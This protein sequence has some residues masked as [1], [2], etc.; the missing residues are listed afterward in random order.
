MRTLG[1]QWTLHHQIPLTSAP[2]PR[3]HCS[4]C[5]GVFVWSGVFEAWC[6]W[7]REA[8]PFGG[9]PLVASPDATLAPSL[10]N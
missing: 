5:S 8:D 1:I 9:H 10:P 6:L 2:P 7:M 3:L 4:F